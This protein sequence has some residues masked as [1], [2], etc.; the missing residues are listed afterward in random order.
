MENRYTIL[1]ASHRKTEPS[2]PSALGALRPFQC[3]RTLRVLPIMIMTWA[4][5]NYK[6]RQDEPSE[7]FVVTPPL[8]EM[9]P[10]RTNQHFPR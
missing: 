3:D 5:E 2:F 1:T 4:R 6:G 8:Y 10:S 9:I 7:Q